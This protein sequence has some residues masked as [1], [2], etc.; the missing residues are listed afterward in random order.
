VVGEAFGARM[1]SIY[2]CE[3]ASWIALECP[4]VEGRLHLLSSAHVLEMVREDGS[5]CDIGEPG[6]VLLTALRSGAMPLVRYE[7]GD[8]AEW[9]PHGPCACGMAL[10]AIAEVH[11]RERSFL[12][13]AD[14]SL[15]LARLTGEHWAAVAPVQ[16]FRLV[17][18]ADGLVEAFLRCARPLT[19]DERGALEA[20]LHEV[21]DPSLRILLTETPRIDWPAGWKRHDVMRLDRLR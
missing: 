2:S 11:G 13:L 16:E 20:M 1:I 12:R 3:E 21:L 19:D 5:P 8:I 17:Q 4:A 9:A 18:Y 7:L 6:K 14:G 15:K 10:P